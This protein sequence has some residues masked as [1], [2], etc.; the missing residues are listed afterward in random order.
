M[1]GGNQLHYSEV[2]TDA[3]E[4]GV[5]AVLSQTDETGCIPVAYSSRRLN[6]TEQNYSTPERECLGLI[7]ALQTWRPFLHGAK[8]TIK[9]DHHPLKYVD[10]QK[11]LSRKQAWLV[12]FVQEFNYEIEYIKGKL[13]VVADALSRKHAKKGGILK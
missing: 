1:I 6:P 11:E 9:T 8:F 3:S 4:T 10:T 12:Q 5:G 13:N 2:T 7:Y